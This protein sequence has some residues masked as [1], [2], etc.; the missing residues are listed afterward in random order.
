MDTGL[1]DSWRSDVAVLF[2][3]MFSGVGSVADICGGLRQTTAR[4]LSLLTQLVG[5]T[6]G[7]PVPCGQEK[8]SAQ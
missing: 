5:R 7:S 1:S 2:I 4:R 6:D 3:R 8:M